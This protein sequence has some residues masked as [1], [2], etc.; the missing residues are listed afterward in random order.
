MLDLGDRAEGVAGTV[1]EER[2]GAQV[3]KMPRALLLRLAR[4]MQR[5][6]EQEQTSDE[7]GV[8]LGKLGAEDGALA[9][10]VGVA[11]E[12]DF[13]GLRLVTIKIPVSRR[14]P[15]NEN[16]VG[17]A[18]R[19][20]LAWRIPRSRKNGETWGTPDL[21][22]YLPERGDGVFQA[23][24]VAGGVGGAGRAEGSGLTIG[25][26]AAQDGEPGGAEGF[27]KSNEQGSLGVRASAVGKDDGVAVG[28]VGEMEEA[29]DVGLDGGVGECAD[30][31]FGQG[32][33]LTCSGCP[34]FIFSLPRIPW[35][36][37]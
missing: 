10:A 17:W 5:V 36:P 29:A 34:R 32:M 8:W 19:R 14:F 13:A 6:G 22:D 27:G 31:S 37:K 12:E 23:G 25:Q 30:G 9:S 33:I 7:A 2:R 16:R 26:I 35:A 3:G 18:T 24:A 21:C 28:R 4:R 20:D 15:P 1:D 11:G